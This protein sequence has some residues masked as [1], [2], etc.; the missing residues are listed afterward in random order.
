MLIIRIWRVLLMMKR[1]GRGHDPEGVGGT[2][3]GELAVRCP[4]CPRPNVNL[5]EG[6]R[7]VPPSDRYDSIPSLYTII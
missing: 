3:Q 2:A 1:A 7:S 5:H 4:A 6:Y